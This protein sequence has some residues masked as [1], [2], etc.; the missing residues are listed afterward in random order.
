MTQE[1][2]NADRQCLADSA[3]RLA[4]DASRVRRYARG[5]CAAGAD[6]GGERVLT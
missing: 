5:E 1:Q 4:I 2:A 3:I 6:T